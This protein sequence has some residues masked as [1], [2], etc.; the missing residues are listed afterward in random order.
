MTLLLL[1]ANRVVPVGQLI[2][3]VWESSPPATAKSQVQQCVSALRRKLGSAGRD[4]LLV[5]D[6]AG[7]ALRVPEDT[8]DV[9][10]F[11]ELARR[12]KLAVAESRLADAAADLR[13]ALTLWRGPACAGVESQLVRAAATRLDE[14][15]VT[16]LETCIDLELQLGRHRELVGELASLVRQYPLRERLRVLYM[17]ALHRSGRK[18]AALDAFRA[19]RAALV[20]ELGLEPGAEL[21]ALHRGILAGDPALDFG[22]GAAPGVPRVVPAPTGAPRQLPSAIADFTGRGPEIGQLTALLAAPDEAAVTD[23]YLPVAVLRGKGGVGK[24]ALAIHAAHALRQDYPDGHLYAQLRDGEGQPVATADVLA[25]FLRALGPPSAALPDGLAERIVTYRSLLGERRVL[26]VLDDVHS[27]SQVLPLIPGNPGCGVIITSRDALSGLH[28]SHYLDIGDL[29]EAASVRLLGSVIGDDRVAGEQAAAL[30]LVRQCGCLPLALRI[31]A[32]KLAA[33]P[34][35]KLA[36]MVRRL[37]DEEKRL[38]ELALGDVGIRATVALS[39]ESLDLAARR[40]F[41]LLGLLG[42]AEFGGWV[43]APLLGGSAPQAMELLDPLVEARLVD[44]SLKDDGTPRFRLHELVRVYARERLAAEEPAGERVAALERILGCWL[45]MA[46]AAHQRTYGGDFAILHGTANRFTLPPDLVDKLLASPLGWLRVEQAGLVSAVHQAAQAGLPELCWDLAMTL[47]TLFESDYQADDWRRT[48]EVA[49]EA[50]RRAGNRLG[51]AAMLYSLGHLALTERPASAARF[52]DPALVAFEQLDHGHG[53]ALALAGLAFIDRLNGHYELALSRYSTALG[54]FRQAGDPVGVVDC[55]TSMA[56][57]HADREE[58]EAARDLLEEALAA[59]QALAAPRSIAQTDYRM[60]SF[61]LLTGKL[62]QAERHL[63]ISL[64]VVR[65]EGDTIGEVYALHALAAVHAGQRR[66]VISE[67]EFCAALDLSRQV[68]EKF[69]HGRVLLAYAE[70]LEARQ[71]RDRAGALAGQAL[72][73]FGE[74]G[75]A[76]VLR[77]RALALL[78]RLSG[79][80]LG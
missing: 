29:D 39:Y 51:E 26:I 40:L 44:A 16:A 24:T 53:R 41:R 34:H 6:S 73:V 75:G 52:L 14:D 69:V 32:A 22:S 74:V 49:L 8:I 37:A 67:A 58:F 77:A 11:E 46:E 23:R 13:S 79:Q 62:T 18:A 60:G 30:A 76:P 80:Q 48:H 45:A 63:R 3:A 17:L 9:A 78:D 65:D 36:E 70:A 50:A 55:L 68:G 4:D 31:V 61:L 15:R 1:H 28:G 21:S 47:V 54:L 7:Y 12:G 59:C 56:Q 25:W 27:A 71:E 72:A 10:R 64:Q 35:W 43:A 19:A 38:D 33:R 20:E 66:H 5:T 57:I 2:E 42:T